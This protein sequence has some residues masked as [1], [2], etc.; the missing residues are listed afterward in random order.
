MISQE[1]IKLASNT[2]NAELDNR[3]SHKT[4]LKNSICGDSITLELVVNKKKIISMKYRTE[5][6]I[7]CEASASVLSNVI[8]NSNIKDIKKDFLML[9]KILKQKKIKLPKKFMSFKK[10]LNRDNI[11]RLKCIFLPFDAVLKA[12]KI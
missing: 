6:C 4:S 3:Y 8:K 7:Y 12:L 2:S 10:L 1:I 5:S 9:K 11:G